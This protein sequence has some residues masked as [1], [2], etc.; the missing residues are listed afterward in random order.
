MFFIN[1]SISLV[2]AL[3][4]ERFIFI[5]I[6]NSFKSTPIAIACCATSINLIDIFSDHSTLL[7]ALFHNNSIILSLWVFIITD[8]DGYSLKRASDVLEHV[9]L[10]ILL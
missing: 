10:K 1:K 7:L 8:G 2:K 4:T 5:F 3:I 6:D 9:S